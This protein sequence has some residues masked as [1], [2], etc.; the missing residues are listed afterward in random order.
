MAVYLSKMAATMVGSTKY[1]DPSS[2]GSRDILFTR[3][4]RLIM[5]K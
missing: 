5:A 3:F 2:S 4:H 1:H